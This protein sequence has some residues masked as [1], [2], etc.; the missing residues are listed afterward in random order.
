MIRKNVVGLNR[1]T[2]LV[3]WN[4]NTARSNSIGA[5]TVQ[6][7]EDVFHGRRSQ[8]IVT[9]NWAR[10]V[11][12]EEIACAARARHTAIRRFVSNKAS[13]HN[14]GRSPRRDERINLGIMTPGREGSTDAI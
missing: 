9:K 14:I 13:C 11:G 4:A 7:W 1:F 12:A 8:H 6:N 2:A 5:S 3:I 10:F